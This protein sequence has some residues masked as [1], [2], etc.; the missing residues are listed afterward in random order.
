M[1]NSLNSIKF[2]IGDIYFGGSL[3]IRHA[4][5]QLIVNAIECKCKKNVKKTFQ[6]LL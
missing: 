2:V 1:F 4:N 3:V 5:N 6:L